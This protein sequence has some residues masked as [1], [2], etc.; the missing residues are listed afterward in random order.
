MNPKTGRYVARDSPA[1][2]DAYI[3]E[4]LST[5]TPAATPS[6][7][8]PKVD[9]YGDG[10][11]QLKINIAAD[12]SIRLRDLKLDPLPLIYCETSELKII[13][14]DLVKENPAGMSRFDLVRTILE[15]MSFEQ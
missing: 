12:K 8:I 3:V 1:G 6:Y 7:I 15:K 5:F 2:K 14:K 9:Q 13:V 11:F 10:C 4:V